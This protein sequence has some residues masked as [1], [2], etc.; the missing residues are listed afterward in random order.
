MLGGA[1]NNCCAQCNQRF[2]V[3]ELRKQ[4]EES[5]EQDSEVWQVQLTSV[6]KA[7]ATCARGACALTI[8]I[9]LQ[10]QRVGAQSGGAKRN[11][12]GDRPTQGPTEDRVRKYF[13][14]RDAIFE[15]PPHVHVPQQK[16]GAASV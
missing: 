9:S 13:Y 16:V 3:A 1:E 12:R 10:V 14:H 11:T 7:T 15:N 6:V 8:I 2:P 5:E 4:N